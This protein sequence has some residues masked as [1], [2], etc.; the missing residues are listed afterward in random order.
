MNKR[1][2]QILAIL[3]SLLYCTIVTTQS[4]TATPR[5]FTIDKQ[6]RQD[7][8]LMPPFADFLPTKSEGNPPFRL[9]F[10]NRTQGEYTSSQWDFG[11]GQTSTEISP[12]HTYAITGTYTVQ[13]KV[14][15]PG[16]STSKTRTDLIK[17]HT[18]PPIHPDGWD[19]TFG[20][21]GFAETYCVQSGPIYNVAMF[22]QQSAGTIV[23]LAGCDNSNGLLLTRYLADGSLDPGFGVAGSVPITDTQPATLLVQN[24]NK[25]IVIQGLKISRF[26]QDGAVDETF[27]VHGTA[28]L[29]PNADQQSRFTQG[30]LQSD[31][32]LVAVGRKDQ[33]P[34]IVRYTTTGA[35]DPT[36]NGNGYRV[37][38]ISTAA[39]QE[40]FANRWQRVLLLFN[41]KL[42]V[43]RKNI[44]VIDPFTGA[45][46]ENYILKRYNDNGTPDLS[47]GLNGVVELEHYFDGRLA[48]GDGKTLGTINNQ[49]IIR[50]TY[51]GTLDPA[52]PTLSGHDLIADPAGRLYVTGYRS[53]R[54]YSADGL[55]DLDFGKQGEVQTPVTVMGLQLRV[56]PTGNLLALQLRQSTTNENSHTVVL[57]RYLDDHPL[58]PPI[59]KPL[60]L[61]YAVLD[62]NLGDGWTRLVNNIEMGARD[63]TTVRLL[64]DGP[65]DNDVFVYDIMQD[66]N[67]F[68]PSPANPTCDGR[69]V[70]G[71]NFWRLANE[72]SAHPDSL[73]Q[74]LVDAV[75]AYPK[76][77]KLALS[78]IG[79][80]SGWSANVLPGQPSIWRDQN[81]TVG[82]MLWDDH[83][84]AGQQ[85]SHS[86]STKALGQALTWAGQQTGKMIDLLYLDGCSMGMAEV[87]YE[88]RNG[89]RYLLA[90]PN[91][92]W[93]SFNYH[94]LLPEVTDVTGLALG[95]RWLQIEASEFR[96]NPGHPFTLA[97]LDLSQ[98][99]IVATATSALA[100]SLQALLPAQ[101][102]Q[103][104]AA[105]T[106]TDRFDSDYDGDLD[107]LDAYSDLP[108]FANQI[109]QTLSNTA[110]IQQAVQTLRSAL[111]MAVVAK[112]YAGGSP[113]LFSN[114]NWQWQHYGGLGI[115]L[116][117]G[118]D[119]ARRQL[120]YH[121][122]NLAW[123]TDTTWDEFLAAFWADQSSAA[124]MLT[125]M[126]V[127]HNT[128]QGCQGLANPLP[129]QTPVLK[130]IFLPVAARK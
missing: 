21:Y 83:P 16:G 100:D 52:F 14:T 87:A 97:L 64:I 115:Y 120:F 15:G 63:G 71:S 55:L 27:G 46:R 118:Q 127:C 82:G 104:L 12:T 96:A 42:M 50:L 72:N 88:V 8:Q 40:D 59:S 1:A 24:D 93:A 29:F 124:T 80:G 62:N 113:W 95:E 122:N 99:N 69:Y 54:R 103:V 67:P 119:E 30:I 114:Q 10:M 89:A 70:E 123:T 41:G 25:L 9:Q 23:V 94:L 101:Q 36:F 65:T 49:E 34:I 17:V 130:F 112:D 84:A 3:I 26:Q 37:E 126:P 86:L 39:Q 121:T 58:P 48:L 129:V 7:A 13:L 35:L 22:Q 76:A 90:S 47:F 117:L 92:D 4:S 73:Y 57:L 91:I 5:Q 79:H 60:T 20:D 68:C 85:E 98:M 28:D 110:E 53:I 107:S 32:K 77:D 106:A 11:D 2:L 6:L 109:S 43:N 108:D 56:E 111:A 33:Q 75:N 38:T 31:G 128:A 105:F 102:A 125:A 45:T 81:D 74:F 61:L 66:H 51:N 116:P 19:L 18:F 44:V 78:L